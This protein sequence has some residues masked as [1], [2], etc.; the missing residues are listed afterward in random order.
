MILN[1]SRNNTNVIPENSILDHVILKL[2]TET[3]TNKVIAWWQVLWG[4]KTLSS[5]LNT[6][7]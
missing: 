2:S 4:D 7:E 1:I 3:G 5:T 6:E